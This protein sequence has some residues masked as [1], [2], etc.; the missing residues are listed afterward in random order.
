METLSEKWN[1]ERGS[2]REI[3]CVCGEN[4]W[5]NIDYENYTNE[6]IKQHL[7]ISFSL[8]VCLSIIRETCLLFFFF[9]IPS[10]KH[11]K[12]FFITFFA[13]SSTS[14]ADMCFLKE[15]FFEA[16]K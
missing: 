16:L 8:S 10:T 2:E 13:S 15:F 9:F 14:R 4:S 7:H 12:I 6:K 11:S 5:L 3:C 1:C